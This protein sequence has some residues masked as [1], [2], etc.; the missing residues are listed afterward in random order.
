MEF[1][2]LSLAR[3][4]KREY[5]RIP[6]VGSNPSGPGLASPGIACHNQWT[7]GQSIRLIEG[8]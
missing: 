5:T 2:A 3:S 8:R 1:C 4:M 6:G 7:N